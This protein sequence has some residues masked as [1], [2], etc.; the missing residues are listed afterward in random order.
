M[1]RVT[2]ITNTKPAEA[3]TPCGE[4]ES[5]GRF[6]LRLAF[7]QAIEMVKA[8]YAYGHIQPSFRICSRTLRRHHHLD[9]FFHRGRSLQARHTRFRGCETEGLHQ[10]RETHQRLFERW[11][12][13]P[14]SSL[15]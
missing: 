5:S 9:R 6:S 1:L 10:G 3:G 4:R 13:S 11:E 12:V 2:H 7:F 8:P 14:W 15:C